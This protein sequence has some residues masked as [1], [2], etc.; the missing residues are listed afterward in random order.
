MSIE[1]DGKLQTVKF[2]LAGSL[3]AIFGFS[4]INEVKGALGELVMRKVKQ[5]LLKSDLRDFTFTTYDL[6]NSRLSGFEA[7]KYLRDSLDR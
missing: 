3:I 6:P 4:T 5:M 7:Y 2:V 1:V